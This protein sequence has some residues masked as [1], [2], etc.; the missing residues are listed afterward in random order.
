MLTKKSKYAMKAL[1]YLGKCHDRGPV[2]ISEL[3]DSEAIPKKF[4]ENILLELKHHGIVHSRKG[5]GGGYQLAKSPEQ[6]SIGRVVRILD[7]P[8]ALTPCVSQT[9]YAKC[10]ECKDETTCSIRMVMQEVRDATANILDQTMLA[11]MI[12]REQGA[13]RAGAVSVPARI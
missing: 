13:P 9:A 11:D 6:V 1:I 4:L 8:L 3:A 2:L 7:G 5:K 10:E 12:R